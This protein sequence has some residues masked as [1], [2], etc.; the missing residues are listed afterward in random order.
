VGAVGEARPGEAAV[1]GLD[2]GDRTLDDRDAERGELLLLLAGKL[3]CGVGQ[4]GDMRAELPEQQGL[5][6]GGRAGGQDADALAAY[7]PPVAVRAVQDV[8]APPGGQARHIGEFIAQP[9]RGRQPPRGDRP[10][11]DLD[12]VMTAGEAAEFDTRTPHWFG[13]AGPQPAELLVLFGPQGERIHVRARP[14]SKH[15]PPNKPLAE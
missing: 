10:G 8:D 5:V 1:I 2:A 6:G 14:R 4:H 13:S 11:A 9:G 12:L 15:R 3:R 7:F